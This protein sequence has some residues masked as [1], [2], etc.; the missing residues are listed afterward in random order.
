MSQD[1][2]EAVVVR[3]VDF[4]ET[5]RIVTFLSP[6]RGRL[7]CLAAGARRPGSRI[8]G[9]LDT[10]N[11]LEIVYYWK[12]SRSVQKLGEVTLLDDF[13][14]IKSD[15]DK[16]AYA[17]FVLEFA[18]KTA[19]ENE[20]SSLL[21]ETLVCGMQGMARW[22]GCAR[23]HAAWQVLQLLRVAG[24]DPQLESV[25]QKG[26]VPFSYESG[27]VESGETFDV[28][29]SS[30]AVVSMKAMAAAREA[31]V[32][33][34]HGETVFKALRGYIAHHWDTDF[35]SLRLIDRICN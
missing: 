32:E 27:V 9:L 18:S 35:R 31:C 17:A 8:G 28:T 1:R 12:D 5:S 29:L 10:F 7:T 30:E 3:G 22:A 15:L 13:Q 4:S 6:T 33:S 14:G 2:S 25:P 11:R 24:F 19:Q 20:P 26:G 21:Y 34:A 16:T 23:V